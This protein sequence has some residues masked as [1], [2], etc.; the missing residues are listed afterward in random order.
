[1]TEAIKKLPATISILFILCTPAFAQKMKIIEILDSNLFKL[2]NEQIIKLANVASPSINDPDSLL[3]YLARHIKLYAVKKFL[4]QDF[5][6]E[7]SPKSKRDVKII[8][9]HLIQ[10]FPF[11]NK[12]INENYL[13]K[14]FGK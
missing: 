1:M 12:N 7:P 5:I 6:I 11:Q 8:S 14:G 10:K 2:E 3:N 4:N 9:A 13:K